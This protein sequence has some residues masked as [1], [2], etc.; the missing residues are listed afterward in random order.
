MRPIHPARKALL[1]FAAPLLL[2]RFSAPAHAAWTSNGAPLCRAADAQYQPHVTTDGAGG[3][4]VAWIDTRNYPASSI[5]S[6]RIDSTGAIRW[7][8]NGVAVGLNTSN[9]GWGPGIATDLSG[10]AFLAWEDYRNSTWGVYAQRLN[11][12]GAPIWIAN[13]LQV[14]SE[15]GQYPTVISDGNSSPT[16]NAAGAVVVW[17]DERQPDIN[18]YA[19]HLTGTG[20]L[21]WASMA[22]GVPV[23]TAAGDQKV[24]AVCTDGVG[25]AFSS[26]GT[27][28][29]WED[30]RAGLTAAGPHIY[31][32]H[33]A[34]SG[35]T[36]SGTLGVPICTA[37]GG[38]HWPQIAYS[39][40]GT[41]IIAWPDAR[42][43]VFEIYAQ[44]INT[45]DSTLWTSNGVKVCTASGAKTAPQIVATGDGGAIIVWEDGRN[46]ISN[47][48]DIYAQAIDANGNPRWGRPFGSGVGVCTMPGAQTAPQV[49]S[50]GAGGAII[51][52]EDSRAVDENLYAQHLDSSGAVIW[53]NGGIPV[54]SAS[55]VQGQATM[56]GVPGGR[57][58]VAWNDYRSYATSRQDIYATR[59]IPDA[60][61]D[62]PAAAPH[63]LSFALRS[64]NPA[65]GACTAALDLPAAAIV[66]A[67][68]LDPQG[69]RV[70]VLEQGASFAAGRHELRW[71]G[72]DGAGRHVA[73]GVYRWALRAGERVS[74]LRIVELN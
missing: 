11:S 14:C 55:D 72:C 71:N 65:N 44:K 29:A 68:I 47:N 33:L 21:S 10:G 1:M 53:G 15:L 67:E 38:R 8:Q 35:V 34:A 16:P 20:V 24:P 5:F 40:G 50:D 54:A 63:A 18:I 69:R 3:A 49:V 66:S 7:V 13:G 17:M 43:G 28:V 32:N 46:I 48:I 37:G 51:T 41:A 2:A 19:Q 9:S 4:I 59:L 60:L 39:E 52:W 12:N 62:A 23:C 74:E 22:T 31:A 56:L 73:P 6:Q 58:I 30:W 36:T 70:R 57:A 64:S 42:S 27:F 45:V 26:K 25:N 61:V